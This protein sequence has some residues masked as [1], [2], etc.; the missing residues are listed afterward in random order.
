LLQQKN[1]EK[2]DNLVEKGSKIYREGVKN[3]QKNNRAPAILQ[4]LHLIYFLGETHVVKSLRLQHDRDS[5]SSP[6]EE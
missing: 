4:T 2:H 6:I 3:P 5:T 1:K